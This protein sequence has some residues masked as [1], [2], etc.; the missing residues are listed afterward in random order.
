M[1]QPLA[2][3]NPNAKIDPSV[4]IDPFVC[5][6][7]NVE[8]GPGCKIGSN[9]TIC[10]GV[11][12]GS[13]VTVFPGAVIGAIPQDLKFKGEETYVYVG[14]NTVIRE[15]VTIHRGTASK[16]KTV[17]GKNCL[18]MAYCHIAHDCLLG[19]NIIMS[20]CT[21]LAGEVQVADWAVIGG[22]TLVHQFTHIGAHVMIQGGSKIQKDIPPYITAAREPIQ[23]CG[24]NSIGMRRRGF[25]NEQIHNIQDCYRLIFQSGL[26]V[27][28][29]MERI[30]AELPS[31]QERDEIILFVRNSPRGILKGYFDK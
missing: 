10:D 9:V 17:V 30:E 8:I 4:V 14:D 18:I 12:L 25:T 13:N 7:G 16:G 31:S 5:I 28:Q 22:G 23:F 21:Q 3:I 19:D 6:D 26:N 27:S 24:V 15:F 1:K 2:Y 20:N 11:R 29:A